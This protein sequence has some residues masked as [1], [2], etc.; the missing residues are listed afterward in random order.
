[1][2][3]YYASGISPFLTATIEKPGTVLIIQQEI[4]LAFN[5]K[6][7]LKMR[8]SGKFFTENRLHP[9]TTTAQQLKLTEPKDL[10]KLKRWIEGAEPDILILDPLNTFHF[11]EENLAKDMSKLMGLLSE[12]KATYNLGLVFSHHFSSKRNPNDP[13]A[14]SEAGGWFRGHS[15][16]SDAADV[17]I[18]LHR[19]PGQRENPNL[20]KD[21]QDYNLVEISLR[22][23]R[24][25]KRFAIE[26]NEETFFL[27]ESTIWQELGKL[28]L[29]GQI[30]DLIENN[31][32][33]MLQGD[34]V[35]HFKDETSRTTVRRAIEDS[36]NQGLINKE[37][38]AK[39]GK[40]VLLRLRK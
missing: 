24:N 35:K 38:L 4:T 8:M 10:D 33:E 22:N 3:F 29:P 2:A 39:P 21:Y 25:P 20:P 31:N 9:Y 7:L 19:L 37:I 14:P 34:I 18:C 13:N 12:L 5:K 1:M 28:I 40:P 17:L 11:S 27:E 6:R 30:T 36:L 16:I 23:E 32:G 26:F 15:S